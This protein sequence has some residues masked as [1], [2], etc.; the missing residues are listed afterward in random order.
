MNFF[1]DKNNKI[2]AYDD[3]QVAQGYGKDLTSITEAEMR[4]LTYVEPVINPKVDGEI[5]TLNSVDYL[6]PFMK[7]DADGLVQVN[8][9][10]EL[11][12]TDTVI[13]FT[14]GTKMPITATDFQDFAVW[15]VNKRNAFFTLG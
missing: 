15:F 3:G 1:K 12:I 8:A 13:Y 9:A 10:F 14:N 2:F 7:D 11:G 4:T 5:Y 6:V